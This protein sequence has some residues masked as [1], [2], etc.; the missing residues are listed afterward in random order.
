MSE[1]LRHQ[2]KIIEL[3]ALLDIARRERHAGRRIVHCHGCF[4]IVH[5]GHIRY[6]EFASRQGD[7][8]VVTL[9]GDSQI[10]KAVQ[11]PYIPQELRAE[12]LAALEFVDYV[13]IDPS[14]T[15]ESVLA[16][17]QPEVYVKGRE[18]ETSRDPRFLSERSV[19]ESY[20]GR[21]IYSSGD[22]VYS[23]TALAAS[24]PKQRD[25]ERARLDLICRR[26]A[27][28]RKTLDGICKQFRG[29]RV[30]VV[31]D[32]VLDRYIFCDAQ[33]VASESPMLSLTELES[34]EY[35]GGAGIVAR[36]AAALGAN[37]FLLTTVGNDAASTSAADTLAD[38]GVEL[39]AL[40]TRPRTVTKTRYLVDESKILKV[41][42]GESTPLDSR[43]ERQAA[44]ILEAHARELDALIICDFGYGTVTASLL[45][46]ILP[47]MRK[48]VPII[49]ADVSGSRGNLLH[50]RQVDLLCPTEREL[51]ST[52]HDFEEGLSSVAYRLMNETQ[53]RH[54]ICTLDKHG[55]VIFQRPGQDPATPQWTDRLQSEHFPSFADRC[56]DRLGCGDAMLATA[57]L[58]LA[59]NASIVQAA[60]LGN[61]ASAIEI[62]K[63]GN[64]PVA[65]DML[66]CWLHGRTELDEVRVPNPAYSI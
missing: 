63:V 14:P 18:Y 28:N 34:R 29:L 12:S 40:N 25:V 6:L 32:L 59:A 39:H 5:P 41:E 37:A 52:L 33:D 27:V 10:D 35:L 62:G 36:H 58:A 47:C 1:R 9:T 45:E 60:Y 30:G 64:I 31:G 50:Y 7:I 61:A 2:R 26:H 38:E 8:L 53:A 20:G 56:H 55:L 49:S 51:R 48:N 24:M 3:D 66:A 21:V 4:D 16:A 11:S 43:A 54:L 44:T 19:V 57:T 13:Y 46:R 22:V 65:A 23:S 15:A 42:Q 17:L